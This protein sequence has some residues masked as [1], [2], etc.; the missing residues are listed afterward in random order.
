MRFRHDPA[1][2]DL[3]PD[4]S[5]GV[6]RLDGI[7]PD[8]DVVAILPP[9]YDRARARLAS[10]SEGEFPEIQAWRRTFTKMG[11]KPT[12]YRCAAEA[13]LRRFRKEDALPSIHPLI[14]LYNA[15][16]LAWAIPIA[17]FDLSNVEGDLTVRPA[18]GTER[19]LTFAGDEETP[20]AG[21]IVFADDGGYAHAR[22][23]S[24][25]QSGR[26][27]IRDDTTSVLLVAEAVHPGA[28]ADIR[29]LVAELGP[30]LEFV[31]GTTVST[32]ILGTTFPEFAE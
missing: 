14:D 1:M 2:Y 23:W 11:L 21:E 5:A 6:L 16:S 10:G 26:S 15:M 22:R 27:A 8:V 4:L 29:G 17:A 25:R 12:Q 9:L 19:Y 24:N 30:L 13:L 3:A 20:E 28:E 18:T 31:W 7:R 32:A